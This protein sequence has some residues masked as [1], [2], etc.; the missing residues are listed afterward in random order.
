[1]YTRIYKLHGS[2]NRVY[3]HVYITIYRGSNKVYIHVYIN[4]I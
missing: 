3:I 1:M 2:S 4:H